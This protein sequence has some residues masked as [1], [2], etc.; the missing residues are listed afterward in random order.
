MRRN[1]LREKGMRNPCARVGSLKLLREKE[2]KERKVGAG[3]FSEF[4]WVS[5]W[6]SGSE[7]VSYE[8]REPTKF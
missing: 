2:R 7:K 3:F 6:G 4:P 1:F 8:Y 5:A